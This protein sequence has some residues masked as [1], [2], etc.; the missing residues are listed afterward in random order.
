VDCGAPS[1]RRKR[2]DDHHARHA[3]ELAKQ[4]QR[5]RRAELRSP[6]TSN[7]VHE[8][9]ALMGAAD[10]LTIELAALWARPDLPGIDVYR[11]V[12]RSAAMLLEALRDSSKKVDQA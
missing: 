10:A 9:T 1:G 3:A 6:S 11:P 5:R 2:C 7:G 8:T 12:L 4:R